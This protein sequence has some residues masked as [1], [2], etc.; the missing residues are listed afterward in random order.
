MEAAIG[1]ASGLI[2]GVVNLLSNE[3]VQAYVASTE[4]GLNADKIKTS[5]FYAQDLLQQARQRGMAEDRPGLQGLVQQLSAK[6]DEA[7]DALDEL[8]YFMFQDQLDGTKYAVPDLGDDLRGHTRHGRHALRHAVGNCIACFSCSRMPQDNLDD[9]SLAVDTNNPHNATKPASA[10]RS[11]AGPADKLTFHRVAMSKKIKLVIEQI[12]PL[13]D[14]VSELLKINPPHAN[15]TPIVSRKRPIIGST[16]TQDTLYGRRDLFEQ[17]L[18]DIITTSATNSSEKFSVLPIVGPGGIGKTTFTQHLYNDKRIDEHFSVRVWICISTDFDVL[19]I[20]QQILSRIEGSNNANQTSLDQLQ[21]SIAQNLKSKRFL[22]V[23]DD[24]WECTDQSWENLLAP[25]MKGE[26]KGSMVLVTTRFPFIAK[27]VKSIN[28]I[29]LEGLE[30]DEFFT[31]F[32]AFVFEGKEPEDYQHALNDVARN[33]AKK[34]KGS[35]LAA[36][37]VGRLLRKDLSREHW[38]GVLENNEWQNQK[39]DDDIMPSLRISYDY[40]PFHL[41]KCFPY[42]ALFPED[43]SFRNLE[44]TQFWIAIGVIDKDEKYMEELLDNGFLVKGN[45]RWGEHYVMHDLLHELSRSVSSQE[46]LNI[47]SSVSFRAD[48]IPK[49]IRHL[50]ITMEDRYEGTFRREM[51]KLRSKIDIVNLRALMIFRAYGENIDKILKETFKEIEGLRV[52]LVEMSSADSLPKNFSKLLHLRYLRVS[53]PYGLSEMSLPSA[54][55]IFYH[56]IFLDL[57]DWRSSSN[58]PEHISRLVNLRHF[59]AKNE[60]HSNVPEVGKLEQLQELKEF[61]VK[62]ETLGFEMEEL[63]KLTHLGG[64]LCLRNLEK[65]ASKEEANKANL[66]LKRSLKTLTLVWGTDQAVAGATDVVDGLQ[67]HDNLRELAIEDHGGGVGPPCWLCHDIPF[68][69]L[70][71]LALAG[72]TWGTL[73]PFGQLPYLKIIRLK[74]IAGVRIIGPDLGFIHLKEVEFDGMPDLEKWDVGP[75]C[76]SFPNLESIVCKNCPKFLALPFFSDC[77]VPC[78]KDIHYPNLSKFLVTECPQ[79]PLPPMPYTSTLIRVLI[80]VE[81][82]DSLGTMSYSGDRLVLRSYGSALAFENM[83]KLDSISFS[84]GSTIPWAELP[85][86][87][88]LRQFLIEED[89]GF[90]SM[91]LLSNL[92][93]S[94]TSLSLIDCENLTA[95]GFNPLIAAVNLKELAVYNTGEN[96]PRS[97]AADLLSELVVASS[98]KLLLPAAGCFQLESLFVD[99]ISAML[100]AP[101]CSLF[102]TT[103]RELYFSCDQR[104]ES[105][106]EEE[107]DALQLLTSLQTLYLWTCPGLP[108]LPQGLHSFSSLTELNVVGCPEIRSLPKGGLPNSLRKL[109]LFDFPEI[110]SLPKEYL[111]TS[112]RE[113]SVFNCSPDLHEQAKELQG[114]KPDLHVYC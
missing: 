3:L 64:E 66:A 6:A 86:L 56:L 109:R 20:S 1:V 11:N 45:D 72:V 100:A 60:L 48:A 26:A 36:K 35:P 7:E 57:Q 104:V 19:K 65:V 9:G 88:S 75:N 92:P 13:C 93:T 63:G 97:V 23:F 84:G 16:T 61:H 102:S 34:L 18:K 22:I 90:L 105:F 114:T 51:V 54:L 25:F 71:S 73:P 68:K 5:L 59:I 91:A 17:T 38:M 52:L 82:G 85:T 44:I 69:H 42:F 41:K 4:L 96:G 87:T 12:L 29:P 74:N 46:C 15:N 94:L 76:H 47:S 70:E 77:L 95:D 30:P 81:V 50:S 110:R 108:S 43:Y 2:D 101:V 40:L 98:T 39:N 112:L 10:S 106:T 24:I 58:L 53:S 67:P 55:P 107:E 83:G 8:H 78:T 28:P 33:I 37:T 113:L 21:I 80:R 79:L 32:E 31:F 27:M 89:P 103:L 99:C 14:R 111:P 49:S 62:K